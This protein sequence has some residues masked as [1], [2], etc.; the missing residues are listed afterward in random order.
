MKVTI[1]GCGW[2]AGVPMIGNDWGACDPTNSKNRRMR[3]SIC[4]EDGETRILIDTSPDLREQLL[5]NKID[6]VDAVFYTHAHADHCHGIDDLRSINWRTRKPIPIYGDRTTIEN[7]THRFDYIFNKKTNMEGKDFYKPALIPH[8]IDAPVKIGALTI[9]A[10]EQ[11]H[12][13]MKTLGF[14]VGGVAYSTD[15]KSM[16]DEAF[17]ALEGIDT[18]IVDCISINPHPTHSHL[19]QTIEWINRVKAKKAFLTHM[20]PALDYTLLCDQ[21]PLYIR[22]AYDGLVINV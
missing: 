11:D 20:G 3:P 21:L 1:L 19:Q 14:R 4:I 10:F 7:I 16:P 17:A 15:V 6:C 18:W 8:I 2:A 13:H 5:I 12:T 22:P 9:S